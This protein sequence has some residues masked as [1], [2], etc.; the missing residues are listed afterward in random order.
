MSGNRK[1]HPEIKLADYIPWD[2]FRTVESFSML[3][4]PSEMRV[5]LEL[6]DTF[7]TQLHFKVPWDGKLYAYARPTKAFYELCA[8]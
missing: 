4:A 7:M 1:E 5:E 3:S 8:G 2:R 6:G